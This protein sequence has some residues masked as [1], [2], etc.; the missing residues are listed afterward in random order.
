MSQIIIYQDGEDLC[1]V[2][3]AE[4]ATMEDLVEVVPAGADYIAMEVADLPEDRYFRDAWKLVGGALTID[5]EGAKEVQRNHWRRLR[6]PKLLALDI[7]FIQ[8]LEAGDTV[9]Q[10]D[11]AAQKTA[12][13]DVTET[14]LPNDLT[15]I[16]FTLPAILL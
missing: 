2:H 9:A 11:I 16:R 6:R 1:V 5:I 7:A 14:P 3:P 8:A 15:G 13:R 10:A 12:L 4:G